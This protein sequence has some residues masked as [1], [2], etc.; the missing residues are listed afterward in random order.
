MVLR[1]VGGV[2]RG[3]ARKEGLSL[4]ATSEGI[5]ASSII[6]R[7]RGKVT[8]LTGRPMLDDVPLGQNK[9]RVSFS[10][11][12]PFHS[13]HPPFPGSG[14]CCN[15]PSIIFSAVAPAF[16]PFSVAL[17]VS[18]ALPSAPVGVELGVGDDRIPVRHVI[19]PGGQAQ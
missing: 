12:P 5:F 8:P 1:F 7:K 11:P 18:L 6:R 4:S 15:L 9:P 13:A 14:L 10:Q 19:E 3:G 17:P 2:L 16:V